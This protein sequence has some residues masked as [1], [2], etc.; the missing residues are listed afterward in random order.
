VGKRR[1][2]SASMNQMVPYWWPEYARR[3]SHLLPAPRALTARGESGDGLQQPVVEGAENRVGRV[4]PPDSD[5]R[6]KPPDPFSGVRDFH[7][8]L[9]E[10]ASSTEGGQDRTNR[11]DT[12]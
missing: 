11:S 6:K 3:G 5:M 12:L 9:L 7:H 8:G 4:F 10:A 2:R 1:K